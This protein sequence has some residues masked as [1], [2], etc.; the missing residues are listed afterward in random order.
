MAEFICR[1]LPPITARV[2]QQQAEAL[3]QLEGKFH[4]YSDLSS[5]QR[6]DLVDQAL[7]VLQEL[8]ADE[9]DAEPTGD[10]TDQARWDDSVTKL[11]EVGGKRAELLAALDI[12]TV[13]DLL[14]HCPLGYEDRS[15]LTPIAD[16]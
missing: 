4:T 15:Q 8:Q 11:K 3:T 2:S 6:A 5:Q 1:W 9:P 12:Y 7:D 13:G 14:L 10:E 16:L